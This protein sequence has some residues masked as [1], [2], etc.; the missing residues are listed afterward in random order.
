MWSLTP[1]NQFDCGGGGT[2]MFFNFSATHAD[3]D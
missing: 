1:I 3:T 2:A